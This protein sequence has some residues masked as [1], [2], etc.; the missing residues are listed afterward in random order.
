MIVNDGQINQIL[1]AGLISSGVSRENTSDS[2][3]IITVTEIRSEKYESESR[4]IDDR[5]AGRR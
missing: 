2:F 5:S 4:D 3:L 1:L